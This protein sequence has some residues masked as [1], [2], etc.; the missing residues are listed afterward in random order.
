ME[1]TVTLRP[2]TLLATALLVALV[3][4]CDRDPA[5]PPTTQAPAA[6][7]SDAGGTAGATPTADAASAASPAPADLAMPDDQALMTPGYARTIGQMAYVW[8]WPIVNMINRRT[9]ITQAPSP[10]L[11][12]GVI[13][14][15]PQG[16]LGMLHNY[17]DPAETFVTCPNQDV[18]YGLG[19]FSLDEQ[20]VVLQVPD[21]GERFW[22]YALYDART[23]QFGQLGK[24]YASKPGFYLIAGPNW[25]GE[26]PEGI[27]DVVRSPTELA[28]IIPRAFMDST[29]EDRTAIQ[30]VINQIVSYPLAEFDGTMKT[31]EWSTLPNI[32]S[33][34]PKSEGET[35][36]IVPE[37]FFDADQ[38]GRA[39]EIV[40]PLPGEEAMYAQ[41]RALL[42]AAEK[43]PAIKQLLV[44]L[45]QETEKEVIQ[46]FF[47][48]KH[49]GRPA[50]NN[51][52]RSVNNAETGLD[53]FNR[54]GTAK[55][56]MF[57]NRP[58]ETQYFYTDLDEAGNQLEGGANYSITFPAGQEPP[59]NGFWSLTLYNDK[60]LF[61]PNDLGRYSL[62]TKNKDLKR[63]EDGSLTLYAG[64]TSPGGDKESNWLPAPDGTFSLYIRAYWGQEGITGGTWQPP[65]IKRL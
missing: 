29:D 22:V 51:W 15:A 52:N 14:V 44:E 45:A 28:N 3:A 10:G 64:S 43:D 6:P 46:P 58:S 56:N 53:Y 40:P 55:S 62:G 48:W 59:V 33:P 38:L 12:D 20:P 18:V 54:T 50:G 13:P 34:G 39:L 8:G 17:I 5:T 26:V 36:W 63:N 47:L 30:P 9:M 57:D 25:D 65:A 35:K 37:R 2:R 24:P 61:H 60:H 21:F 7:A 27:T 1:P 23:N 11:L 16:Q 32:P 31:I 41:F 19:F 42:A 49:N 4:A